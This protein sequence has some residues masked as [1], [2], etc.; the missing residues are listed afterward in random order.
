M[1]NKLKI[2]KLITFEGIDG[3]G[4]STQISKLKSFF[5]RKNLKNIIFTREPGGV[6]QSEKIRK[7][8]LSK[9]NDKLEKQTEILLL[10]AARNE[11][12]KTLIRP[13][14]FQRKIIICDRFS[15][16]TL[17]YQ[18]YK[19]SEL[20][21]F[22]KKIHYMLLNNFKP[23]L[24]ILLDLEP[25][26][27]AERILKR[28]NNNFFDAKEERYFKQIRK[29]YLTLA[30]K[31]KNIKIFNANISAD[32]LFKKIKKTILEKIDAYNK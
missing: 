24:S 15:H 17:A 6:P 10:L 20:E 1:Q 5:L 30:K 26:V 23:D 11:H 14:L 2:G 16:S 4:K 9:K 19:D 21:I 13:A 25:K 32:E 27:A 3:C 22:Y 7:L 29:K 31:D 8:L 28:S 12:Y 18:C